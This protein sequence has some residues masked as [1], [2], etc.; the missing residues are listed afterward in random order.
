VVEHV[1]HAALAAGE[2]EGQ[3]RAVDRPAQPGAGGDRQVD[4]LDGCLTG[5]DHVQR[6]APERLLQPVGDEAGHL[7]VHGDDGLAGVPVEVGGPG[8]RV[9]RGR[10]AADHLDQRDEVRRVERVP[11]HGPLGMGA[12]GLHLAHGVAG[13]GGGDHDVDRGRRVD[14]GQQGALEL[15]VLGRALLDEV[16]TCAGRAQVALDRQVV[17]A[18][19]LRQAELGQRRPGRLHQVPQPG[20]GVLGRIPGH[21]AVAPRQEVR[22]PPPADDPGAYA[23]D[24]ADVLG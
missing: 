11:D 20:L 22:H 2:V 19:A 8:D 9:G 5:V 12:L 17:E 1:R 23:G 10:G 18:R 13:R 24:G 6:L 7:V 21:H 15:E 16:G 3:H 4:L 14:V